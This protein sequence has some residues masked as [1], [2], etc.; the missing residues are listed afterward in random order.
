MLLRLT[1]TIF[2]ISTV[3]GSPVAPVTSVDSDPS[4]YTNSVDECV[5]RANS[6]AWN[7]DIEHPEIKVVGYRVI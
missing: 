2:S 3:D 1:L 4:H 7:Y 5:Q 6:V